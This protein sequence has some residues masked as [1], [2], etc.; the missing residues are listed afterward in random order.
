MQLQ[1]V[2][3]FPLLN[4]STDIHRAPVGA[5]LTLVEFWPAEKRAM[6]ARWGHTLSAV[7]YPSLTEVTWKLVGSYEPHDDRPDGRHDIASEAWRFVM[8]LRLLAPGDVGYSSL[9]DGRESPAPPDPWETM[10]YSVGE[11]PRMNGFF[12]SLSSGVLPRV[13]GLMECLLRLRAQPE[14]SGLHPAIRRFGDEYIRLRWE[15]RLVDLTVMLETLSVE[16]RDRE[17][18]RLIA[19]RGAAM[20]DGQPTAVDPKVFLAAMY[21]AR[22]AIVH[23]GAVFGGE[24]LSR[25]FSTE[26]ASVHPNDVIIRYEDL[27]R[28]ILRGYVEKVS[29]GESIAQVNVDLDKSATTS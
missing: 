21:K 19:A 9:F 2:V 17:K 27:A 26:I 3:T 22:N 7:G 5:N 28:H 4:L 23:S 25:I 6:W 13:S 18:G 16:K 15:D 1:R 14:L 8:A 24:E 29:S 12:Y 20:L 10:Q 11:T